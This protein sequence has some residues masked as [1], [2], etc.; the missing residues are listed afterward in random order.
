MEKR[1]IQCLKL[2]Y[3]FYIS[4]LVALSWLI[5]SIFL[6]IGWVKDLGEVVPILISIVIIAGIAYIPGYINVFNI[7]SLLLDKQPKLTII[8]PEEPVTIIIACHNE[9]NTIG[10]TLQYLGNQNYR[11]K[12]KVIVIDNHS[13]DSTT[14]IAKSVGEELGLNLKVVHEMKKG[15]HHALNSV[16]PMIDTQYMITL[17][18]DTLLM[19]DSIKVLMARQLSSSSE[20]V[21]TAGAVLTRNS[22]KNFWTRIQEWDYFLGIASIKRLQGMYG[23]TLVAQGAYSVYKTEKIMEIGG[24]PDVIGEDIVITWLLLEKGYNVSFE[25]LAVAFTD[26]PESFRHLQKQRSRWARGMIEAL[27]RIKPWQ[28]KNSFVIYATGLNM[29]MPLVDVIYT[30]AWIPGVI[31]AFFGYTYIAGPLTLLVLPLALIQNYI[32]YKY[33]KNNVFNILNLKIRKNKLGYV[34]YLLF[35]QMMMSPISV[36]GYIEES[37]NVRRIWK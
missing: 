25:P 15:K 23:G 21:A 31:L 3:K 2:R 19:K 11:G 36:Y 22:R 8:D 5:L 10:T 1:K 18:A 4:H 6:S 13:T 9:E 28:H 20:V 32:L 33:Q 27:K 17:D 7:V 14:S 26:V 37:L 35:Y 30:L 16:L 34:Y 29:I 24:Y 12:I